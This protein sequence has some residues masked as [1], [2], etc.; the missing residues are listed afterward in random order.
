MA[1]VKDKAQ[2]Q[3]DRQGRVVIPAHI[4]EQLGMQPGEPVVLEIVDGAL[5]IES[6]RSTIRRSRG[7]L[8]RMRPEIDGAAV[9]DG[10]IAERRAWAERE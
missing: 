10:L 9:I 5:Q 3:V 7:I 4:R 6:L 1:S 2:T 8:K